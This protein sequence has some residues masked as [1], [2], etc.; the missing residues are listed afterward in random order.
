MA[1]RETGDS[2]A[3]EPLTEALNDKDIGVRRSAALALK[4]IKAK[5]S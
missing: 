5:K 2:R 1:L 4:K 3:V